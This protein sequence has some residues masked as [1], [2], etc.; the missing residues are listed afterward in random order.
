MVL[1]FINFIAQVVENDEIASRIVKILNRDK[2]GRVTFMPLNRLRVTAIH[3]PDSSDMVPM[4]KKIK[5]EKK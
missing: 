1:Y 2:G 4:I 5:Y 3:Y